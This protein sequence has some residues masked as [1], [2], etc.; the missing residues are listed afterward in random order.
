MLKYEFGAGG[1]KLGERVE[2]ITTG[3]R[4]ILIC[5]TVHISGCNTY[6]ILLPNVLIDGRMKS[7]YRDYLMLRRLDADESMF[8]TDKKLTDENSFSPK[9]TDVNE[10]WIQD[11]IKQKKEFIPEVDDAVGVEEIAIMPGMEVWNKNHGRTMIVS[12]ISRDIFAKELEYGL[13]FMI[14]DNER[15]VISNSYAL[16]PLSQK[17]SLP[18]AL[19]EK[20][21][22][23]YEDSR[24][25]IFNS[26]FE[27]ELS[28][29]YAG[30]FGRQ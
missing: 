27:K 30:V 28:G 12:T 13:T 14:G 22:S 10:A 7:T 18:P 1:F 16:I 4:G 3:L 5:E 2:I 6:Q 26:R 23:V 29:Y 19:T 20:H 17:F 9:G 15:M 8:D 25:L 24:Q 21:G 11:A